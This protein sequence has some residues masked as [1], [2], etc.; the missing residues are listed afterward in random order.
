MRISNE[1]IR[2]LHPVYSA[3]SGDY[4]DY[5]A[6]F[7]IEV[8]QSGEDI[9]V[10]YESRIGNAFLQDAIA[11]KQILPGFFV[12]CEDTMF[13]RLM[14]ASMGNGTFA[15]EAAQL[16]GRVDIR[17][18]CYI[19]DAFNPARHESMNDEFPDTIRFEPHSL[20]VI[21]PARYFNVKPEKL[22]PFGNIYCLVKNDSIP[23][24]EIRV[25]VGEDPIQI[26]AAPGTYGF[27][28]AMRNRSDTRDVL[29]NAVYL[30][31][32]METLSALSGGGGDLD[33]YAWHGVIASKCEELKLNPRDKN[34]SGL[35]MAQK[36]MKRPL[37]RLEKTVRKREAQ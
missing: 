19:S 34:S 14:P 15:L 12:V 1:T 5:A 35:E 22:Q 10:R 37:Q 4:D 18:V 6:D 9:E 27:L 25:D 31:A 3:A 32:V 26:A 24:G 17:P 8:A 13:N 21:G 33:Q 23:E 2:Y 7:G 16:Y 36:L 28:T 29:M 20:A 30:P 11:K